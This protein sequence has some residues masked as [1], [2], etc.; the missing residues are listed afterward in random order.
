[1]GERV[2]HHIASNGRSRLR[3]R[4]NIARFDELSLRLGTVQ[5]NASKAICLQL[6]ANLQR[7]CVGLILSALGPQ[8]LRQYP[9][10]VLHMVANLVS[11]QVGL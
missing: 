1:V 4:L 11:D 10:Q 3:H 5:P 7:I 9:E 8:H 6:H 2:G